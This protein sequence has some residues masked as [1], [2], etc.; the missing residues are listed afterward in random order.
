M[1]YR[2]HT[3]TLLVTADVSHGC[4]SKTLCL[5]A[6]PWEKK[7]IP[8]WS[9]SKWH[10][11]YH[12]HQYVVQQCLVALFSPVLST[13][14]LVF[15]L[16]NHQ[17]KS[18]GFQSMAVFCWACVQIACLPP[19]N[20]MALL[21]SL[22]GNW[23]RFAPLGTHGIKHCAILLVMVFISKSCSSLQSSP[24]CHWGT[25]PL[26]P[27]VLTQ[28]ECQWWWASVNLYWRKS[29]WK[30]HGNRPCHWGGL[31]TG[32]ANSSKYTLLSSSYLLYSLRLCDP[33]GLFPPTF[34]QDIMTC[35]PPWSRCLAMVQIMHE[36]LAPHL[37]IRTTHP[38]EC[39]S[40]VQLYLPS[41]R[42]KRVRQ[43][44]HL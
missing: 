15:E 23:E 42:N 31:E 25:A 9:V 21:T 5:F 11:E 6:K 14:W 24:E 35:P 34:P 13:S 22:T 43:D 16:P 33:R 27:Y 41:I 3:F 28:L 18:K 38:S 1:M 19:A 12:C 17:Q 2:L 39:E 10:C 32:W 20:Y 37:G 36:V 26:L 30:S 44:L 8:A 4:N 40:D 7:L 29:K